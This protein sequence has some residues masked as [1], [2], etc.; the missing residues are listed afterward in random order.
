MNWHKP[1]PNRPDRGDLLSAVLL[2]AAVLAGLAWLFSTGTARPVPGPSIK[3]SSKPRVVRPLVKADFVGTWTMHWGDV[4]ARTVLDG[5]GGYRCD[6]PGALYTGTWGLDA[7]GRLWLTES[8]R[9][10]VASSWQSYEIILTRGLRKGYVILG[11]SKIPFRLE[12]P[13]SE[14]G[15]ADVRAC[16]Q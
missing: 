2:W 8:C 7:R 10:E 16:E 5:K 9:P 11:P 12:K 13:T 15:N 4:K 6:W 14:K 1:D 3:P